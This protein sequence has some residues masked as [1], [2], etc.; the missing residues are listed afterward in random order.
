TH[1]GVRNIAVTTNLVGGIDD[2]NSLL[3]GQ[4]AGHFAQHGRLA[5]AR[6]T[7]E[8]D[9]LPTFY[10]VGHNVDGAI[11]GAAN[12][13]GE[14]HDVAATVADGGD[15][16]QRASH[17]GAVIFV[18]FADTVDH[19]FDFSLGNFLFPQRNLA[20]NV[21]GSGAAS[22]IHYNLQELG[23]AANLFQALANAHRQD[24]QQRVQIFACLF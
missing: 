15:A 22:E 6:A 4:N 8:Q 14:A 13:G 9:A 11:D 7:K 17:T 20:I 18:K 10:E 24:G 23:I 16:V 21:A 12:A 1:G 3:V 19:G 5:H 2:D